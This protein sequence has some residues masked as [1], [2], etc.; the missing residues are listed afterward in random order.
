MNFAHSASD[1]LFDQLFRIFLLCFHLPRD[2]IQF[3]TEA[4]SF[5]FSLELV[6]FNYQL[7]PTCE[8]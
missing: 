2:I 3:I 4:I 6:L 5:R 8:R 7:I 1:E